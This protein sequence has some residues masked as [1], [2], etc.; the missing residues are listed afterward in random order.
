M[1]AVSPAPPA[2]SG[3]E[4]ARAGGS[5]RLS[6][7][8]R[9]RA[10]SRLQWDATECA[11]A[12]PEATT[13]DRVFTSG[14]D[15]ASSVEIDRARAYTD[16]ELTDLLKMAYHEWRMPPERD[17]ESVQWA[18]ERFGVDAHARIDLATVSARARDAVKRVSYLMALFA[19]RGRISKTSEFNIQ[20][21]DLFFR[22][23]ETIQYAYYGVES[24]ARIINARDDGLAVAGSLDSAMFR[25]ATMDLGEVLKP[26]ESLVLFLLR[27]LAAHGYRRY[28]GHCYEQVLVEGPAPPS[29]IEAAR[30]AAERSG[31][32]VPP[33][34]AMTTKYDTHAWR[35]VCSI[36]AFIYR[37]TRKEVYWE[38]WRNLHA[39]GA[40]KHAVEALEN[41]T[42]VE[43][44]DL[45]PNRHV[46]AFRTGIYDCMSMTY[47]PY[48]DPETRERN[49]IDPRL[50]ACKY[51][52]MDFPEQYADVIDDWYT[53]IP[54][55]HFQRVLDYQELG[56]PG[57]ERTDVCK[58]LYVM[59]GRML[60]DV[61]EMDQWQVMAFIKGIAGS[62]K[63]TIIKVIQN[64]YPKADVAVLSANCQ[65]KFA[66]ESLLDCLAFV[67]SEVREDFRLSQGELQ[68]MISG[69]DVAINRKFKTVETRTWTAP[70][71]FVG[72]Q[73]GN[74]IDAQGSMTR[75]FVMWEFLRKVKD[76][77]HGKV[78]DPN[79]GRKI[80]RE[81][82]LL[83]LKCNLAYR[84]A[85]NE[86]GDSDIWDVLPKYFTA[87]QLRL[88]AQINPLVGFLSDSDSIVT[89]PTR[90]VL[91][92]EFRRLYKE[93]LTHNNFG[94]PPKFVPDHYESVFEEY[95]LTIETGK[96]GW[97]GEAVTAQWVVGAAIVAEPCFDTDSAQPPLDATE[98]AA[99]LSSSSLPFSPS[100]LSSSSAFASVASPTHSMY[101]VESDGTQ[102][103]DAQLSLSTPST[104]IPVGGYF[105]DAPQDDAMVQDN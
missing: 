58:W 51:F 32:E 36:K 15:S 42:D 39:N 17:G 65:E 99:S 86:F 85:C 41:C 64:L 53:D 61:G 81:M 94:R 77:A 74:W 56:A 69:E 11:R 101:G 48:I 60:Y 72:N 95:G 26:N 92:K 6:A 8:S 20:C 55:P 12:R 102:H 75:R 52:N 22:I 5:F 54:T 68:S 40:A 38:Q 67:C 21:S 66:L 44:P 3:A 25:F 57:R 18:C 30:A 96:R 87:T 23:F 35:Q 9:Q 105:T 27:Q 63:S 37:V 43:F 14:Y 29:E 19:M 98:A 93:W 73:T 34:D 103:D 71:F 46:F 2:S 100:S 97:S 4:Q 104:P 62:G 16:D 88:K 83:L 78:A 80:A 7:E 24:R 10:Q 1:S 47:T 59:I 45:V 49:H 79:L 50:V 84:H 33:L 90:Y 82:P 89:G 70:G 76:S 31:A 91:L 13:L 28:K